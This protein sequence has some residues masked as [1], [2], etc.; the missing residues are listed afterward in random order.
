VFSVR[1]L[2]RSSLCRLFRCII[3]RLCLANVQTPC[4]HQTDMTTDRLLVVLVVFLLG[5][6]SAQTSD[7]SSR[8]TWLTEDRGCL[9]DVDY[10]GL[11]CQ[12]VSSGANCSL[13]TSPSLTRICPPGFD[14]VDDCQTNIDECTSEPCHN[15]GT[16]QDGINSFVCGCP[17]GFSGILCQTN[18]D[19]CASNPCQFG[20]TCLNQYNGYTCLC[21]TGY[22]GDDCQTNIDECLT[23]PCEHGATCHDGIASHTCTCAPGFSGSNCEIDID[24]CGSTPCQNGATCQDDIDGFTCHCVIGYSGLQC[25]TNIDE[26]S[27][28]PCVNGGTCVDGLSEW[29]CQCSPGFNGTICDGQ[30]SECE[31]NPCLNGGICM[32]QLDAFSCSCVDGFSGARCQT[33]VDECVSGPC[34]NGGTCHDF[35]GFYECECPPGYMFS[36]CSME[37]D[38]CASN[39]SCLNG[40]TCIDLINGY[41]CLCEET[42]YGAQC[43]NQAQCF[44]VAPD[45][46]V[47]NAIDGG[48]P[49]YLDYSYVQTTEDVI[50]P[51][52]SVDNYAFGASVV[53][54]G[55]G[56]YDD[57]APNL[58]TLSLMRIQPWPPGSDEDG[59]HILMI[60]TSQTSANFYCFTGS[61]RGYITH[62]VGSIDFIQPAWHRVGCAADRLDDDDNVYFHYDGTTYLYHASNPG[63]LG[64]IQSNYTIGKANDHPDLAFAPFPAHVRFAHAT[65]NYPNATVREAVLSGII[66][67][68]D[69]NG[70][71]V[72]TNLVDFSA[73]LVGETPADFGSLTGDTDPHLLT[74]SYSVAAGAPGYVPCLADPWPTCPAGKTGTNCDV[75]DGCMSSPCL[76]GTTCIRQRDGSV[77]C[78][79]CDSNPCQND[80]TCQN[81]ATSYVCLCLPGFSGI[82]CQTDIDECLSNPCHNGGTCSDQANEYSCEC[83]SGTTGLSC[84]T[85]ID[86]CAS[87]PCQN[88]GTCGD[89]IDSWSCSCPPGYSGS[90]CQTDINECSSVPCQNGGTCTDGVNAY[91]CACVAGYTGTRCNLEVDECASNPCTNG[92]VC[93]DDFNR[94][95]CDCADGLGGDTCSAPAVLRLNPRGLANANGQSGIWYNYTQPQTAVD[96][97]I[98][99]KTTWNTTDT[100][101]RLAIV[102]DDNP[103]LSIA[104]V[105]IALQLISQRVSTTTHRV[106]CFRRSPDLQ[107][108]QAT[109]DFPPSYFSGALFE[110]GCDAHYDTTQVILQPWALNVTGLSFVATGVPGVPTIRRLRVGRTSPGA[111]TSPVSN[112]L[113]LRIGFNFSESDRKAL[114]FSNASMSPLHHLIVGT[115]GAGVPIDR[116][117][118]GGAFS[119]TGF[120]TVTISNRP[121]WQTMSPTAA[122]ELE[123]DR[124]VWGQCQNGAT[125]QATLYDFTCLCDVGWT[126]PLCATPDP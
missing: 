94:H 26:C 121:Q 62:T 47:P 67:T 86:E 5:G 119:M 27:S 111:T 53:F 54:G 123:M 104:N 110:F 75:V 90:V 118:F 102:L 4:Y 36:D 65:Y 30:I 117:L 19:E 41:E 49:R 61:V 87:A 12:F 112:L 101:T 35:H 116:G 20:G 8:G 113:D 55:I 24:E 78:S 60:P 32:D 58:V 23:S 79:Y 57:I 114:R 105:P 83:P 18:I 39:P 63:A 84:E 88:G 6:V 16:C 95:V 15:G 68:L 37:I 82:V 96:I 11:D 115:D 52:P 73:P 25:Q 28:S 59:A 9:C 70:A 34:Q 56:F 7:C 125:C 29:T 124:C 100:A 42:Y 3:H 50:S 93:V 66:D 74:S 33:N 69:E 122:V 10:R 2:R 64:A 46:P 97:S 71:P 38:E 108:T 13:E 76:D 45:I 120:E 107:T 126:G 89:L 109:L 85:N 72:H 80:A 40:G 17:P 99:V 48:T 14:S 92:G 44:R 98:A 77:A 21:D 31:S 1:S 91:S 81:G 43:E 103:Q 51:V 106:I 22:S